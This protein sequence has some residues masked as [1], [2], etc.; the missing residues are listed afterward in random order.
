M[1]VAIASTDLTTAHCQCSSY[2]ELG[3]RMQASIDVTWPVPLHDTS[4][5]DSTSQVAYS[6]VH[7]LIDNPR[8]HWCIRVLKSGVPRN[9]VS[10]TMPGHTVHVE[11]A[12]LEVH[13]MRN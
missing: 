9:G 6:G 5:C 10:S 4:T 12:K 11:G 13:A 2:D 7:A 8:N 1:I 3:A